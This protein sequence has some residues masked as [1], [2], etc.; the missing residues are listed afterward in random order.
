MNISGK[1][2]EK[3]G[4]YRDYTAKNLSDIIKI[5][6]MSGEEGEVIKKLEK[7]CREAGFDEVRVDGL[8]NLIGRVGKGP[9]ILAIDAHI[10][11]VDTGDRS[12]WQLDPF[13]GIIKDDRV[14]GRGS[15][16]QKGGAASMITSARILKELGYDGDFSIYFTFSVME[17]DCDGLCWNYIIEKGKLVP[18]FAV[19][20]EPT[21]LSVYRGHR[22]R[23]EMEV[24]FKGLSAHG[25]APERGVNA[26]YSA[27]RASL[28]I[29]GLNEELKEDE[30]LGKGS[31]AVTFIKSASP[32]LCAIPDESMIHIDRR[33]TQGETL[34]RSVDEVKKQV[35]ENGEVRVPI[36]EKKSYKGTLFKQE[37]YFPTWQMPENHEL[38]SSAV[39]AYNELYGVKPET[40]KWV[41]S[42]NGVA[43]CGKH[44]IA[45]MGFGPG[46]EIYAHAPNEAVP[47]EHLEKASAFY[48][49]LPYVVEGK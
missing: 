48:A 18:E 38:I 31:A 24:Y 21:N 28:G 6:S 30:F 41:F 9:R 23:M 49:F 39:R 20:T 37:K 29:E 36:Y 5:P 46:N 32:S 44:S 45:S 4:E 22:G 26:I 17:E 47:V 16:D 11:T 42:T 8:G 19:L 10:D 43:I 1:I 25:S 15:V 35:G 2:R 14:H 7:L 33:L 27:S 34:E 12:M 13:S 40:G 3:A